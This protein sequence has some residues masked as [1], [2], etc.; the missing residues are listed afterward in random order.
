MLIIE[1]KIEISDN[2]KLPLSQ[3]EASQLLFYLQRAIEEA[4]DHQTVWPITIIPRGYQKDRL[5][6]EV[7]AK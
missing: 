3:D 5:L 6:I 2:I 7:G 1:G 4:K